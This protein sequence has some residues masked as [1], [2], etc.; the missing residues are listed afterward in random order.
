M[1]ISLTRCSRSSSALTCTIKSVQPTEKAV[2]SQLK[3]EKDKAD[4]LALYTKCADIPCILN[5][6]APVDNASEPPESTISLNL[7]A[8]IPN[9]ISSSDAEYPFSKQIAIMAEG[10]ISHTMTVVVTGGLF[11]QC[12]HDLSSSNLV[13]CVWV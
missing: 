13:S 1:R 5:V 8:G 6:D 2:I 9:V 11:A 12:A 4:V 3:K 7:K 10:A